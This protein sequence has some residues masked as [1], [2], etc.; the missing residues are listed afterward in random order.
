MRQV[1]PGMLQSGQQPS[2]ALRQIPQ[3]SSP[4]F[5]VQA[6]INRTDETETFID[7]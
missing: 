5:Q 4:A 7:G 3:A 6:A 2:N 1:S